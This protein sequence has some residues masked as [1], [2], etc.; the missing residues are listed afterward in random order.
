MVVTRGTPVPQSSSSSRG[1]QREPPQEQ[2]QQQQ[3]PDAAEWLRAIQALQQ[4]IDGL[5]DRLDTSPVPPPPPPPNDPPA[6][7]QPPLGTQPPVLPVKDPLDRIKQTLPKF[8]GSKTVEAEFW[9]MEFIKY[10]R[11]I[12]ITEDDH[13]LT[14]FAVAMTNKAGMWW[15]YAEKSLPRPVTWEAAKEV[16][17]NKYSNI[18]KRRESINKLKKL[19]KNSM[20]IN[21]FFTEA[22]DLNLY[23]GLDPETLPDFLRPGL[24]AALQDTLEVADSIQPITTYE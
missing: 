16:F 12:R 21:E 13:I 20:T 24:N 17:L 23:A 6:G 19:Y 11:L 3:P 14:A 1:K 18:L 5:Q 22:E 7:A 9:L 4:Q 15:E 2:Q 8:D 10:C